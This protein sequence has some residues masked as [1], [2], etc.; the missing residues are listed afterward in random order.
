MSARRSSTLSSRAIRA[1]RFASV[2][3]TGS[4]GVSPSGRGGG[5]SAR[6]LAGEMTVSMR[7]PGGRAVG[8]G[9]R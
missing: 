4:V 9:Q 1:R 8:A 5:G 7:T 6:R 3:K 2:V